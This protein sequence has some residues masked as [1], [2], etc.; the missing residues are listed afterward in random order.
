MTG[1]CDYL[2]SSASANWCKSELG[3]HS[4]TETGTQAL[5][6]LMI[7]FQRDGFFEVPEKNI[8]EM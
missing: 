8:P 7:V 3:S 2:C 4:P 6:P 1:Q 5:S